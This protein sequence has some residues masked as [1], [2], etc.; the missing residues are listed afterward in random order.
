MFAGTGPLEREISGA[1]NIRNAGFQSGTAL[2]TLIREARF[3][4]YP[5][6][7]YENCPFSIMES[8]LYGTPVWCGYGRYPGVDPERETGELF[9]AGDTEDL[10]EKIRKLWSDRQLTGQYAENCLNR[11]DF[12]TV[13][14][15]CDKLMKLYTG[16]RKPSSGHEHSK[17]GR[18]TGTQKKGKRMK[19]KKL[20]KR[21]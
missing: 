12:D 21:S 15:Y 16:R 2:E 1:D 20:K 13:D 6:E 10:K 11:M 7:W 9:T 4:V 18:R 17:G 5:S 3:T 19:E 14:R 8:Q